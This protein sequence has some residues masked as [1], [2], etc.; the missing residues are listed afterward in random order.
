MVMN[1]WC[2]SLLLESRVVAASWLPL[3][4]AEVLILASLRSRKRSRVERFCQRSV[5]NIQHLTYL[6]AWWLSSFFKSDSLLEYGAQIKRYLP[7]P[8]R[9]RIIGQAT[10][11]VN[12]RCV[13][14]QQLV[15]LIISQFC[16]FFIISIK[17]L[18][19]MPSL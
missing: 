11:K 10:L 14:P 1:P 5:V 6:F 4:L 3:S 12:V 8:A 19:L 9:R 2:R 17:T 15:V 16:L 7:G 18:R 13:Y